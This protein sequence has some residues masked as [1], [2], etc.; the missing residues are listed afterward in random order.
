MVTAT[1]LIVLGVAGV[2]VRGQSPSGA[3]PDVLTQLLTEV[4]GLRAAMEQMASA[5]PRV[6]LALG[7]LQLQEQ[8]VNT[9]LR[10]METVQANLQNAERELAQHQLQMK[11]FEDVVRAGGED[12][13]E[14]QALAAQFKGQLTR[15]TADVQRL[16]AEEAALSADITAEQAR[17]TEINQRLEELERALVGK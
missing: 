2:V 8:R 7:R 5:G 11:Q 6:Q 14:A 10:R 1:G 15:A 9:M 17:W 3:A 13:E 4:R 12:R 16:Q